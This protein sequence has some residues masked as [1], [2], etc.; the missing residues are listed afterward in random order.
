MNDSVFRSFSP[1][2]KFIYYV[3]KQKGELTRT[4][5]SNITQ[6]SDRTVGHG[7]KMLYENEY[8]KKIGHPRD[9]RK[10]LYAIKNGGQ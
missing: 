3:L 1:T 6:V 9:G 7:L 4:Q 8:I 5:I 2:A 10:V